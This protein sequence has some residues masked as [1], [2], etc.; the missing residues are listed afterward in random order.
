M[1]DETRERVEAVFTALQEAEIKLP[2]NREER[3]LDLDLEE[4][5]GVPAS[6]QGVG[7]TSPER[8]RVQGE[9]EAMLAQPPSGHTSELP[10]S[11]L[12]LGGF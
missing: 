12:L 1:N 7:R 11:V 5:P 2:R 3:S 8:S 4:S 10:R 6:A 9:F